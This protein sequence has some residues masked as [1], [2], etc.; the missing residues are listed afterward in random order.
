MCPRGI[1]NDDW[2]YRINKNI[3]IYLPFISVHP[4][5]KEANGGCS[6]ECKKEG[7]G[8][9]C[10]CPVGFELETNEKTC[11]KSK[12]DSSKHSIEIVLF[13]AQLPYLLIYS[14]S[15]DH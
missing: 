11:K 1:N 15:S 13:S 2:I 3:D 6:H 5:D 14:D 9:S 8:S 7:E 12:F 4:C 10:G